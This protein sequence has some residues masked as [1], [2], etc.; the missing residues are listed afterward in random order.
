MCACRNDVV[1]VSLARQS[2]LGEL[3]FHQPQPHNTYRAV[4]SGL[5]LYICLCV[6][7]LSGCQPIK[8]LVRLSVCRPNCLSVLQLFSPCVSGLSSLEI[9][10]LAGCLWPSVTSALSVQLLS[11]VC[12]WSV[13]F[14]FVPCGR[15]I[16]KKEKINKGQ[17]IAES[18][19]L[20]QIGVK[21][22]I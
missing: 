10:W 12:F 16:Q 4:Q 6:R 17:I 21:C 11:A 8:A 19:N 2:V 14:W 20:L 5:C 3:C 1:R 22:A 7:L 13:P 15:H 18:N 9:S